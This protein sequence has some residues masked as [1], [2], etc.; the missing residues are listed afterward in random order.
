M[1]FSDSEVATL[2]CAMLEI[3]QHDTQW[4]AYMVTDARAI[5]ERL[6]SWGAVNDS[7]L[8]GAENLSTATAIRWRLDVAGLPYER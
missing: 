8:A 5:M 7:I 1:L 4:P 2:F 3:M 6:P